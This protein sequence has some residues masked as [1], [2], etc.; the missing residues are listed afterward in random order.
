MQT[1]P[2]PAHVDGRLGGEGSLTIERVLMILRILQDQT[3][4]I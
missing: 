3:N 2:H 1:L 4:D